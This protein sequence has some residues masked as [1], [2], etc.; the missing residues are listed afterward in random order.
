MLFAPEGSN[1]FLDDWAF[2]FE[3]IRDARSQR[4]EQPKAP[5]Y[6]I[7]R[8]QALRVI[9]GGMGLVAIARDPVL[10]RL[11]AIKLW[12]SAGPSA[13]ATVLRSA[14]VLSRLSHPNIAPVYDAGEYRSSLYFV[15]EP[16]HGLS[17]DVWM[18]LRTQPW[19]VTRDVFLSAGA[20]LAAAH[21]AGVQHRD[22]RPT[23]VLIG[24]DG[25]ILVL[26]FGVSDM[27]RAVA[28][29]G[30][31]GDF[32]HYAHFGNFNG[33]NQAD[34][35]PR[36]GLKE[37]EE[38][39]GLETMGAGPCT[40]CYVAPE[41]LRGGPGDA[42]SDLFSF[43]VTLWEGLHGVVPYEGKTPPQLLE[44]IGLGAICTRE[45]S[46]RVPHWLS[47]VVRKGL[48][49]DPDRRQ[50]SMDELLAAL[51]DEP[52]NNGGF[53]DDP[54]DDPEDSGRWGLDSAPAQLSRVQLRAMLGREVRRALRSGRHAERVLWVSDERDARPHDQWKLFSGS[55]I[56]ALGISGLSGLGAALVVLTLLRPSAQ[57]PAAQPPAAQPQERSAKGLADV[58]LAHAAAG[59]FSQVETRWLKALMPGRQRQSL[60]EAESLSIARAC[61]KEAAALEATSVDDALAGAEVARMIVGFVIS[62]GRDAD[63]K[64]A[65]GWIESEADELLDRLSAYGGGSRGD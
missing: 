65:G 15:T 54:L 13:A 57:P 62:A 8:Y 34:G 20:G 21:A 7:G 64:Q 56:S 58:I 42:R 18:H 55:G 51:Q 10:G 49:D 44:T 48:S 63:A 4:K 24:E 39:F 11:V 36:A 12:R 32:G 2:L 16:V 28:D 27:L 50:Q 29:F 23:N 19:Q 53:D 38:N 14:Q 5:H 45:P 6:M 30:D 60:S 47:R 52:S 43:C 3:A 40:L 17:A 22:F 41:R 46:N 35:G 26:D 25:R 33:I 61:L 1:E 9:D 31:V 59:E 37:G